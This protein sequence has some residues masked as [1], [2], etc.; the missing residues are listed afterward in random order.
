M[1]IGFDL[2]APLGRDAPMMHIWSEEATIHGWLRIE[3]EL[4]LSQAQVGV[5]PESVA[6]HIVTACAKPLERRAE[7]WDRARTVGYPILPLVEHLQSQ[8]SHDD[9]RWVHYAATT[10]DI[11]DT[12]LALQLVASCDRIEELLRDLGTAAARLVRQYALTIMAGRTHAQQAVPTTFGAKMAV[13]LNQIIAELETIRRIRG[14]VRKVSLFGAAGTSAAAGPR[15]ALIR[16]VLAERL[17]LRADPIPWHVAREGIAR[18]TQA[19]TTATSVCVRLAREVVDLSR[20]EFGEVREVAGDHRGA[21]STMPQKANPISSEAII[22]YGIASSSLSQGMHRAIEAGHERSAGE[23]QI[24]WLVIPHAAI[25]SATAI[26]LAAEMLRDLQVFPDAMTANLQSDHGLIMSEAQM[27][28]LAPSIGRDQAH[29]LVY[30][31]ATEARRTGRSLTEEITAALTDVEAEPISPAEYLG[32]AEQICAIVLT[33]WE[34]EIESR[35][36]VD[37]R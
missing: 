27:M 14:E 1:N 12:A 37:A 8:L 29:S 26:S 10:Q 36:H 30:S 2:L 35:E 31:A 24:E 7:F 16:E 28:G 34:A 20:S 9:A 17:D 33:R 4:A 5:F 19:L 22:G 23:W 25:W 15:S 18:F 3:G 32:E 6:Q 21:S 13:F 11:M